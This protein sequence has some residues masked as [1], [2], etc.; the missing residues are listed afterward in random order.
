MTHYSFTVESSKAFL[1]TL[2]NWLD[3]SVPVAIRGGQYYR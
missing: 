1:Q 3:E 2:D